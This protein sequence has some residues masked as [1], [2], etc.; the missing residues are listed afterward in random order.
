MPYSGSV[1]DTA[2]RPRDWMTRMACRTEDPDLFFD[3]AREHEARLVCVARCPVRSECLASVK[4]TE[5]GE[6]HEYR[7]GVVAALTGHERWR[8]DADAPVYRGEPAHLPLAGP[9]PCGTYPAMLRHLWLDQGMDGVCWSG[10]VRREYANRHW[11]KKG[12]RPKAPR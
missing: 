4:A 7:D 10:E 6:H 3:H 2:A 12:R 9:E 8:L 11:P 1:P 5:R